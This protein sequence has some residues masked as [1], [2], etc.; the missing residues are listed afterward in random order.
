MGFSI[1]LSD[2]QKSF[3]EVVPWENFI[4]SV[5]ISLKNKYI[6]VET[7]KAGCSTVKHTLIRAE[8]EDPEFSYAEP[9]LMHERPLSPLLTPLQLGDFSRYFASDGFF[10]FCFVRNP[11]E[12]LL[13][14]Y[15]DK[16]TRPTEQRTWLAQKIGLRNEI[17]HEMTFAEFVSVICGQHPREM[18]NHWRPQY[19]QTFQGKMKYSFVGR[20]ETLLDDFRF[21][22]NEIGIDIDQY[23]R[24]ET[25]HAQR[26][27]S[28]LAKYY[29]VDLQEMVAEKYRL[30]F[31]TFGY[32]Y[33]LPV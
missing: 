23:L 19:Y 27:K 17:D 25:R 24:V 29:D 26:S 6:Y 28:K 9:R 21:V 33:S 14:G 22:G 20:A 5:H 15:L 4:Y 16:I 10:K 12:R 30:D 2:E 1:R 13:S 32:E 18:D 31:E 11:Y 8:L 7:P 3:I